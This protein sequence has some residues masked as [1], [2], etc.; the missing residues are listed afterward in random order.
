MCAI[1]KRPLSTAEIEVVRRLHQNVEDRY[2]AWEKRIECSYVPVEFMSEILPPK[3]PRP[4]WGFGIIYPDAPYGNEWIINQYFLFHFGIPIAGPEFK[5]LVDRVDINE[6]RKASARDL[7]VE[8][9]PKITDSEWLANSHNQSYFILN[10]CR[11]LHAVLGKTIGSKKAAAAWVKSA[12]PQWQ[13]LIEEAEHWR[14]G[15]EIKRQE[16]SQSFLE[17]A[18]EKVSERSL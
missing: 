14:Y 13:N 5:T 12:H 1:V 8:W 18:I 10:L 9:Q 4:W 2:P 6:V 7:F 15:M 16:E 17:F 3:T 11:I